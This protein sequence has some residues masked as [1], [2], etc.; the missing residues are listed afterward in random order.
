[1]ST[2]TLATS[3]L[4]EH[5]HL[6]VD[7]DRTAHRVSDPRETQDM[8]TTTELAP[9]TT[10]AVTIDLV[11]A[12]RAAR[13]A[14]PRPQYVPTSIEEVTPEQVEAERR[15]RQLRLAKLDQQASHE[16]FRRPRTAA[17][18][19]GETVESLTRSSAFLAA[20]ARVQADPAAADALVAAADAHEEAVQIE[21]ARQARWDAYAKHRPAIFASRNYS[22]LL[23]Q[24]NPKEKVSTWW[25]QGGTNLILAGLPGRGK[26]TAAY[27]ICNEVAGAARD[28]GRP[29]T[30]RTWLTG[31]LMKAKDPVAV[32]QQKRIE[33]EVRTCD[34]LLLDDMT[35]E[36]AGEG[37]TIEEWKQTLHSVLDERVGALEDP[38]PGQPRVQ[39]RTIFTLNAA[40]QKDVTKKLVEHY[41][42]PIFSRMKMNA[43][44]GWIEGKEL[45]R[46]KPEEAEALDF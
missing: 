17:E 10:A 46:W 30:V 37:W 45:R 15:E 35:R 28:G 27:A 42:D 44:A 3:R 5:D 6:L 33:Q 32:A 18:S 38:R 16:E 19:G 21:R 34:L 8:P 1:V 41:G 13:A 40:D 9:P 20:M 29:V 23:P 36:A 2:E 26:T 43:T 11:E 24:M 39:R 25:K 22:T 7:E 4:D 31:D 14:E 12:E